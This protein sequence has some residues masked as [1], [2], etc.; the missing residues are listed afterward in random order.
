MGAKKN[1]IEESAVSDLSNFRTDTR[2]WLETNCPASMRTPMP[3]QETVWGGRNQQWV[4]E[5]SKLWLE[6]MAEKGWTVPRWPAEYGGGGL[7]AD[8]DKVLQQELAHIQARSPLQSFG[9]W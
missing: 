3:E 5:D 7:T 6:R 4:N 8:E 9:I 2:S 1:K